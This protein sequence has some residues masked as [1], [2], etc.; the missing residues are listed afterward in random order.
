MLS[1]V[2]VPSDAAYPQIQSENSQDPRWSARWAGNLTLQNEV[3][4]AEAFITQL[5]HSTM[6]FEPLSWLSD[7]LAL[8]ESGKVPQLES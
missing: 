8:R 5:Q 1:S 4:L 3:L 6:T 2:H 7:C